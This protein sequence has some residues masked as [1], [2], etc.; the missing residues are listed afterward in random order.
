EEDLAPLYSGARLFAFPSLYEG[1]GMP[2]LEAMQCGCPV[3]TSTSSSLPEVAGDAG[4]L[5]DPEDV[6][7]LTNAM[8]RVLTDRRLHERL[9]RMGLARAGIFSWDKSSAVMNEAIVS[10]MKNGVGDHKQFF[11]Q[12]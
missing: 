11:D 6:G 12:R 8:E 2:V 5:V 3:V 7:A 4:I 10:L 9:R 1:F